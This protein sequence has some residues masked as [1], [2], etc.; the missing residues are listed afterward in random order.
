MPNA[1][2]ATQVKS[3][4]G[5]S[6]SFDRNAAFP[7]EFAAWFGSYED[8]QAAAQTAVEVGSTDSKYYYGMQLYV[9]DGTTARTYL[10]QGDKSLKEIGENTPMMFVDSEDDLYLLED[11]E[12]GHQVLVEGTGEIWVFKGGVASEPSNW[13]QA[14]SGSDVVWQGTEDRVVFRAITQ[15]AFDGVDPKDANTLYFITDVG[16]IYKGSTDVTSCVTV[17]S[18]PE[19]SAAVKGKLYIDSNTFAM[20]I[21]IDGQNWIQASPGYLTDG[22]EW[23]AADSSK[24]ATI[25]LIKKGIQAA[26][27]GIDITT[28][29]ENSSGTVKV[30][31]DGTGAV[32][33]GVAHDVEYDQSQLR[34]TIP[35]YGGSDVVVDIPK[36]KFVTAG[37][38]YADYPNPESATHHNVIV[39]TI[40][41]QDDPVIIP[42]E[43]LVDVYTADNT[44]KDVTVVI[45]QDNKVSASVK[46]DPTGNNAL[47]TSGNGLKVDI[48]GKIDKIASATGTKIAMTTAEGGVSESTYTITADGEMGSDSTVIPTANLIAAAISTAIN[49]ANVSNKVDKVVGTVD[50][51]VGF[52]S[53]GAIKDSGKK[54]GG[55]TLAESPDA[56]TLATE[57]AVKA[58]VDDAHITWS[59]IQ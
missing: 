52:A 45:S 44:G 2:N 9:F 4:L 33:T 37:Q 38:F 6:N 23:A 30:G 3:K 13:V 1:Y 22:V 17:G 36:D 19:A 43:A 32:L 42:A 12:I 16:K 35:V 11:L 34:I 40:D 54:S 26:V 53:E 51:F 29:F 8:A 58:A 55:A 15:S 46:I 49:N 56:N 5:W 20:A 21:T 59:T 24:L 41:G 7:L 50:N 14:G 27:D 48:S 25:G 39:L 28:Y 10:I 31:Q 47:V 57:A 18:I